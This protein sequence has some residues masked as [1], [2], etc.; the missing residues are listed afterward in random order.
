MRHGW[1]GNVLLFKKGVVRDVH[2]IR[3][4]GLEPRGALNRGSD[5]VHR[6]CVA[7]TTHGHT[8]VLSRTMHACSSFVSTHGGFMQSLVARL[9]V[10][11]HLGSG[12]FLIAGVSFGMALVSLLAR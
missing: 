5:A 3:L 1:H 10:R 2:Q 6:R 12:L 11:E 8:P 9:N 7:P 4:P